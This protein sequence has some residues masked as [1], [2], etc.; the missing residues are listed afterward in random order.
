V[1][2]EAK[3]P[4]QMLDAFLQL[5]ARSMLALPDFQLVDTRLLPLVRKIKTTLWS[6]RDRCLVML[7]A[8]LRLPPE[9][10]KEFWVVDFSLP[11]REEL[12]PVL[13]GTAAEIG[14][15]LNGETDALLDSACG[16]TM[17]E[18]VQAYA[19]ATAETKLREG[20]RRLDPAI[21]MR[22]KTATIKKGGILEILTTKV[23]LSNIGGLSELKQWLVKRKPAFGRE[24]R[25]Y[26][27]PMP[28]GL[29][30]VGISG[31]GKSL[32]S[33]A[34]AQILGVPLLRMDAGRIFGS[35][36][37]ESEANLRL[38]IQ[39]AEAVAPCVLWMDEVEKGLGGSKSS[40]V[41]DGGTSG[42]VVG[43]ML[44]WMQEKTAPVFVVSTA[45]DVSQLPPEMLRKGR[46]D[47]MFF[48]DLPTAQDRLEIW[49]IHLKL[50]D[51]DPETFDLAA[52]AAATEGFTGA[53]IESALADALFTA[54]S[55]GRQV[56]T[57]DLLA[58]VAASVPLSKTMA[59][60]IDGLR[61][62]A[63]GRARPANG[64]P[65]TTSRQRRSLS[66]N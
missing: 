25:A 45:N 51:R 4:P 61:K 50:K 43:T 2:P 53:E 31:T 48:V 59:A 55:E 32:V 62:W 26:G 13:E 33:K 19:I 54:F 40:G 28:K 1:A 44:Q 8:E 66:N 7:G 10:T 18:A 21:V 20:A 23:D 60:E 47:E 65:V 14:Q 27:L 16:L 29:L 3:S 58:A 46:F 24:A 57:G 35:R 17:A 39:T 5:P 52:A 42:R 38:A 22:E 63:A 37:G 9:L 36:V 6:A 41:T 56:N 11:T 12:R 30:M 49:K 64:L 34:T 15:I